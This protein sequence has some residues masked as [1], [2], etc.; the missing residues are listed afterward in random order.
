MIYVFEK[1][2]NEY[3]Y[4]KSIDIYEF[5]HLLS[6]KKLTNNANS[7]LKLYDK[8]STED[9]Y[10]EDLLSLSTFETTIKIQKYNFRNF[11]K[12]SLKSNFYINYN[13]KN[14]C[15]K[16]F[17]DINRNNFE[18]GIREHNKNETS[19][20][21]EI[22]CI[23]PEGKYHKID[24]REFNSFNDIKNYKLRVP[25]LKD[26]SDNLYYYYL[27]E[28]ILVEKFFH[29]LKYYNYN[30]Y[31]N[32]IKPSFIKHI[33]NKPYYR[34]DE[35]YYY[36]LNVEKK[37]P[38]IGPD[39]Y[40]LEMP[41]KVKTLTS[42][43]DYICDGIM[44]LD[45]NRSFLN[46]HKEYILGKNLKSIVQYY[47]FFGAYIM[48]DYLRSSKVKE[49]FRNKILEDNIYSLWKLIRGTPSFPQNYTVF[50]FIENDTHLQN[51]KIGSTWS[52]PGFL[53]TTR[54]SFYYNSKY[55]FGFIVIKIDIPKNI[56]GIGICLETIS[57]FSDEL[58]ILLPPGTQLRLVKKD[59]NYNHYKDLIQKK[60]KK[61][62]HFEIVGYDPIKIKGTFK[63]PNKIPD[64]INYKSK[65]NNFSTTKK[66]LKSITNDNHQFYINNILLFMLDYDADGLYS[67]Y[68]FHKYS[69]AMAI[70]H[71]NDDGDVNILCE[72]GNII[73]INYHAIIYHVNLKK[74]PSDNIILKIGNW[75]KQFMNSTSIR[76]YSYYKE[77]DIGFNGV[78]NIDLVNILLNKPPRFKDQL[79]FNS[80]DRIDLLQNT[81]ITDVFMSELGY[82]SWWSSMSIADFYIK[83]TNFTQKEV[84][85]LNHFFLQ[86]PS[87][88]EFE[89]NINN[90]FTHKYAE[91]CRIYYATKP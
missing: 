16:V 45:V 74:L 18:I 56:K 1:I 58:E 89:K 11:I 61:T 37:I 69:D 81:K 27:D 25:R 86:I 38:K 88:S 33:H 48:N 63:N 75:C 66:Y 55:Q 34:L 8:I 19:N 79:V 49:I 6:I 30:L 17:K 4:V 3:S 68:F 22:L 44:D 32:C 65:H 21:K 13:I 14:K 52:T 29:Y 90:Y 91:I 87:W 76:I 71:Q 67:S 62:Y 36:S 20:L 57:H 39:F 59:W 35:L 24:L 26:Y 9:L 10:N 64:L 73:I 53:S 42:N 28:K 15:D 70:C 83:A 84:D 72:M 54:D 41:E 2:N 50:R 5:G 23:T 82:D 77:T 46:Y 85:S 31:T 47:S 60:V 51:I 43:F 7:V 80:Y 78:Y 12:K 40:D